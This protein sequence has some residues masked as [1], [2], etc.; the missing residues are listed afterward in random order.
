MSGGTRS[1]AIATSSAFIARMWLGDGP[2]SEPEAGR[3][4]LQ[5]LGRPV[6]DDDGVGRACPTAQ[7]QV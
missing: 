3:G 5:G 1:E 7:Q 2:A 6:A 4:W